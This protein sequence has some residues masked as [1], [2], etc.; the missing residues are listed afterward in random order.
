MSQV[1]VFDNRLP[2][3]ET[4][5]L[6]DPTHPK[7][8]LRNALIVQNQAVADTKYD[9][10][11]PPRVE[12]F[13]LPPIAKEK[14]IYLIAAAITVI[15]GLV[16]LFRVQ[17]TFLRGALIFAVVISLHYITRQLPSV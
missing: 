10:Y 17:N 15:V 3:S 2:V 4:L 6:N 13:S 11:P 14:A 8:V 12:A 7:N 9:I 16:L 1:F 5:P